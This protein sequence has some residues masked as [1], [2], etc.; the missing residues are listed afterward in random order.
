MVPSV[1]MYAGIGGL[2]EGSI[3]RK[4]NPWVVCALTLDGDEEVAQMHQWNNRS[5]LIVV[6][7][8]KKMAEVLALVDAYLP[9]RHGVRYG[10]M[11][12][13]HISWRRQPICSN[14]I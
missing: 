1:V 14:V 7:H 13:T 8:M 11:H 12:R 10:L 3:V 5:I 9:C 4:G 2:S 6:H